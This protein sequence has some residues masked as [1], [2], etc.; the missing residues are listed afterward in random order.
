MEVLPQY[1][2]DTF[3]GITEMRGGRRLGQSPILEGP[4][5]AT[6]YGF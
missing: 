6:A 1:P 3:S 5:Q 4:R 2:E